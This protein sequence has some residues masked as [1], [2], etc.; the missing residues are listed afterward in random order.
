VTA[1]FLAFLLKQKTTIAKIMTMKITTPR[2]IP[3]IIVEFD[4]VTEHN[5]YRDG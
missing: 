2:T 5:S 4:P 3:T 1:A